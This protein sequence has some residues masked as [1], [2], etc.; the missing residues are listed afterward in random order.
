MKLTHDGIHILKER[1]KNLP[2]TPGVYRMLNAAGDVLYVGKAK[3]L[4][5]RVTNY[6]Q[7]ERLSTRIRK[8][9][10][11]THELIV[12][13]TATE[14]EALLL[15]ANLIKSLKPKYNVLLRDDKSYV[16]ILITHDETPLIQYHRGAKKKKGDYFGPYPS[17]DAVYRTLDMLERTFMLRT[18]KDT[19]FKHRT[20]PCLKFDIKRCTAP[21]VGKV[22]KEDYAEQVAE[23]KMFLK[24]QGNTVQKRIQSRMLDAAEKEDFE[25]AALERDKLQT[26]TYINNNRSTLT[27]ALTDADVF[28]LVQQGGKVAVQMFSYRGGQHVGNIIYYPRATEELSEDEIMR[29]FLALHYAQHHPPRH[30][31]TSHTPADVDVLQAAFSQN[32]NYKVTLSTPKQGERLKIVQEAQRN[33]AQTLSRKMAESASWH[34]QMQVF[35]ELLQLPTTPTRIEAFDISNISGTQAVASMVVAGAEDM[36]KSDYRKFTIKTKDTP[37][38][39]AMMH[40]ALTRRYSKLMR[41]T[42]QDADPLVWPDIILVDG[43][44]GHLNTLLKV[45]DELNLAAL[46]NPPTLCAIAKGEERD[47]GLEKIYQWR[48]GA[49]EQLPIP[50]NTPLIFMLQRVRDEAHRFAIGFHRQ[51]RSKALT[52][53]VLDTI[54]NIGPKRKKSLLLHFGAADAVKNASIEELCRVE[55]ISKQLAEDIYSWL[56]A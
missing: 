42:Q 4:K 7:A 27:N 35:G 1:V 31:L 29:V 13:E 21:C 38:D 41:S 50:F 20:R 25:R 19:I 56:H 32:A 33:A 30:I 23:A 15:E 43:G 53:S 9:V 45:A 48:N 37:D 24:G 51:R 36:L 14:V 12:V 3:A 39:Y 55:G 16:S 8:M 22:N 6:T 54:P 11:E 52:K 17:S 2:N 28:G 10:F 47:K 44:V 40:E 49:I 18:C 34:S 5:K 26:L 46:E